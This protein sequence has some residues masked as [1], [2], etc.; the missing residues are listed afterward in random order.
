MFQSE[1]GAKL[2]LPTT[3]LWRRLRRL[4]ELGYVVIE[5]RSGRNYVRLA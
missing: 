4:Q 5:R 1:L 3:T 2:N